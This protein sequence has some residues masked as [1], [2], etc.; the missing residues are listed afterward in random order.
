MQLQKV[1]P[2]KVTDIMI[3]EIVKKIVEN[4]YP[5][6]IV[7][8]GSRVWGVPKKWSDIDIL[9]IVCLNESTTKLA[10][11]ISIVAKP[12]YVPMDILVRT[13]EEIEHRIKLGDHFIRKILTE[14]KVL[15]ER[16]IGKRRRS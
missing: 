5:E 10:S 4:F 12:H 8:F 1:N 6:K 14:G 2:P 7:L 15:Y 9:V 3:S 11:K 13:P 16:R